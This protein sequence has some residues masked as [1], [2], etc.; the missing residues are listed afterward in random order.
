MVGQT[1]ARGKDSALRR[2]RGIH[3]RSPALSRATRPR[4]TANYFQYLP[5]ETDS[6]AVSKG[7]GK[8][9]GDRRPPAAGERL[10]EQQTDEA[11]PISQNRSSQLQS[12]RK[13]FQ[14]GRTVRG[15]A[16]RE[17]R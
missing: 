1:P 14:C 5:P 16:L 4:L 9:R 17:S 8:K 12:R 3:G 2:K 6:S 7:E 10:N 13:V 15:I 11:K